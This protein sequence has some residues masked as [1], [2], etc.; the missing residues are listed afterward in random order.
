MSDH[1]SYASDGTTL[2]NQ[3]FSRVYGELPDWA[4]Q[5]VDEMDSSPMVKL[6]ESIRVSRKLTIVLESLHREK[7]KAKEQAP[8]TPESAETAPGGITPTAQEDAE[9]ALEEKQNI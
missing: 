1:Q 2:S 6:Q 7:K 8:S 4:K 9:T 5:V 3:D